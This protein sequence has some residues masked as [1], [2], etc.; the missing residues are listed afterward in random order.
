MLAEA[1]VV[2]EVLPDPEPAAGEADWFPEE[3]PLPVEEPDEGAGEEAEPF[4]P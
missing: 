1:L 3:L 4:D 2:V